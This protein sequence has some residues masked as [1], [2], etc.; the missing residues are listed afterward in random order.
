[1]SSRRHFL[2]DFGALLGASA[3]PW[4]VL[5]VS[6]ATVLLHGDRAY[7]SFR[8]TEFAYRPRSFVGSARSLSDWSE[9]ELRLRM[10]YF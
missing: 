9:T 4:P 6:A 5:R 7:V 10:P 8:A 2:R 3:I 1:M